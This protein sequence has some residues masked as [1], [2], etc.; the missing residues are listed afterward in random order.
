MDAISWL[1]WLSTSATR[2][3][4]GSQVEQKAELSVSL[5]HSWQVVIAFSP[6]SGIRFQRRAKCPNEA[7]AQVLSCKR[8][9]A[10]AAGIPGKH[11]RQKHFG[12][13]CLSAC[14]AI[15]R[16]GRSCRCVSL[17]VFLYRARVVGDFDLVKKYVFSPAAPA[18]LLAFV[19][20]DVL[21]LGLVL[22]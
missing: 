15:A 4:L 12:V 1:A 20:V 9:L 3:A 5:L 7:K 18:L 22:V 13:R 6:R 21:A 2:L 19:L 11:I 16:V 14:V 10:T 17:A 8:K